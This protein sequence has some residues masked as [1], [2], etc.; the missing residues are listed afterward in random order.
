MSLRSPVTL[1][2]GAKYVTIGP[3]IP[4]A[5]DEQLQLWKHCLRKQGLMEQDI[6]KAGYSIVAS[7]YVKLDAS[8]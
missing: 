4:T 1:Q 6:D 2:T 3:L 8:K 5:T 7:A